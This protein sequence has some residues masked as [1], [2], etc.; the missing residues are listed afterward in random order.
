MKKEDVVVLAKE[1][2]KIRISAARE[3]PAE[4]DGIHKA[5][6]KAIPFYD[7]LVMEKWY[8]EALRTAELIIALGEEYITNNNY[9]HLSSP[10]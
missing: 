3:G 1:L 7:D 10:D 5:K 9:Q 8:K 4:D 2:L 6:V